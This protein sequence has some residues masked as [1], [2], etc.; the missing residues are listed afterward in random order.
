[1]KLKILE[2]YYDEYEDVADSE[3]IFGYKFYNDMTKETFFV[4]SKDES[5]A[6]YFGDELADIYVGDS[7]LYD[8]LLDE[9]Y[10][11]LP[12]NVYVTDPERDNCY[13]IR[14][15][16][17][18]EVEDGLGDMYEIIIVGDYSGRF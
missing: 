14:G 2:N 3:S 16:W 13:S 8:E 10:D 5:D 7:D 18:I 4:L 9:Y 1:M 11:N 6:L 15:D 17:F 12:E